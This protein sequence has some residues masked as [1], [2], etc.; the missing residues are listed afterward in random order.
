MTRKKLFYVP[1]LISL[2]WLPI[3][4]YVLVPE[5]KPLQTV[6]SLYLPSDKKPPKEALIFSKYSVYEYIKHKKIIEISLSYE[7]NIDVERENYDLE[8][9]LGTIHREIQRLQ[10]THDM[11][12]VLKI[13]LDNSTTYDNFIWLVN[14]AI[15]YD[16]KR[17]A[18]VD[19]CFYFLPNSPPRQNKYEGNSEALVIETGKFIDIPKH[20]LPSNWDIFLSEMIYKLDEIKFMLRHNYLLCISF[21]LLILLPS[22]KYIF[23][24]KAL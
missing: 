8:S 23:I 1:G 13:R 7:Y 9:R 2:I 3:L 17:Y 21:L 11:N 4:L 15:I 22:L 12:S 5:D 24:K 10:Y 18:L 20:P 6:L 14:Q 16:Y 19:D